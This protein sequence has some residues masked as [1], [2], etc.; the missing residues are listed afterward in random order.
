MSKSKRSYFLPDKLVVA[1]DKDC[2]K[3][4]FY[5]GA[6]CHLIGDSASYCHIIRSDELWDKESRNFREP[7]AW[8]KGHKGTWEWKMC[9]LT[10]KRIPFRSNEFFF[11]FSWANTQFPLLP[12]ETAWFASYQTGMYTHTIRWDL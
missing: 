5:L 12:A 10:W 7:S 11:D 9:K 1:F 6:M 4:S 8:L 3:A 2:K